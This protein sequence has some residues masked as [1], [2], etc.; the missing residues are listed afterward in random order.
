[1]D[2]STQ[3]GKKRTQKQSTEEFAGDDRISGMIEPCINVEVK[4][5]TQERAMPATRQD[6][7]FEYYPTLLKNADRR[8]A[9]DNGEIYLMAWESSKQ[10][11]IA[12]SP[13]GAI[14]PLSCGSCRS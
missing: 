1:V 10:A 11:A 7:P 13:G 4:E 6:M 9:Y 8:Y 12:L 2:F 3:A 14:L 5:E